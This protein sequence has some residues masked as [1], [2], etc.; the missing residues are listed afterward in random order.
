[1]ARDADR[2]PP[3]SSKLDDVSA[4]HGIRRAPHLGGPD[5]PFLRDRLG[6][7]GDSQAGPAGRRGLVVSGRRGLVVICPRG[8]DSC[9]WHGPLS[10]TYGVSCRARAERAALRRIRRRFAPGLT[11]TGSPAPRAWRRGF[12]DGAA[13]YQQVRR[14]SGRPCGEAGAHSAASRGELRRC[15]AWRS[16]CDLQPGQWS[17]RPGSTTTPLA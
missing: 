11:A 4:E 15:A 17:R 9:L 12:G 13:W 5:E 1:M 10:A 2:A 7:I 8:A 3:R 6:G 14:A 16:V